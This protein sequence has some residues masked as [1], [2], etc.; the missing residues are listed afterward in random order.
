MSLKIDK[1]DQAMLV[2]MWIEC[3]NDF[4]YNLTDIDY[5]RLHALII[6][7]VTQKTPDEM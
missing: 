3:E 5:K 2:R 7:I 1:E 6:K 4:K